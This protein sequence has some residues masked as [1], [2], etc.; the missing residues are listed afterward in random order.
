MSKYYKLRNIPRP[1]LFKIPFGSWL[2]L[3]ML[4]DSATMLAVDSYGPPMPASL[5]PC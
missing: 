5:A 2:G 4:V 3:S 1:G